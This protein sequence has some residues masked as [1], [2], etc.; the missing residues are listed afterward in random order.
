MKALLAYIIT[1]YDLKFGGDGKRPPN[2]S[3]AFNVLPA[4]DGRVMFRAR[5]F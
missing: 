1:N 4:L 5:Q 2:L 3:F